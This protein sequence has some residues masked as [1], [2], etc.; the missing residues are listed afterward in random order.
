[1]KETMTI[2]KGLKELK[3]IGA[4]IEDAIQALTVV[5]A[6]K[7]NNT[8]ISGQPV[9]DFVDS[10]KAKDQSVR[11]LIARRDAIKRAITLSNAVTKVS[12]GDKTYTVAEAIDMKNT[13]LQYQKQLLGVFKAQLAHAKKLAEVENERLEARAD[14]YIRSMYA[15]ADLKNMGDE[16]RKMRDTFVAAQTYELVDPLHAEEVI[17][18]LQAEIDTFESEIDSALS[19]SNALTTIEVEY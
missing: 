5:V 14:E 16:I 13:G 2:H 10:V 19:V 9:A 3:V 18:K 17:A 8:K 1:M 11:T 7:H 6:S 4:R 12:V 15:G